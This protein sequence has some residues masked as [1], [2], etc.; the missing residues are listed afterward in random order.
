MEY[1]VTS[2]RNGFSL[3]DEGEV[4]K[5]ESIGF[6][7]SRATSVG[8]RQIVPPHTVKVEINTLEELGRFINKFG[9]VVMQDDKTIEIY[10]SCRE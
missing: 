7:F 9:R 4:R 1:A 3:F 6:V 10:N 5:L 2:T 8:Y